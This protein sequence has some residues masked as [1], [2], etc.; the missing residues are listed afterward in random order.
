MT[1]ELIATTQLENIDPSNEN[2]FKS[3][4]DIYLGLG[5]SKQFST[6][7]ISTERKMDFK[8]KCRNFLIKACIGIRKRFALNEPVLVG[9]SKLNPASCLNIA[10]RDESI[11]KTLNLMPRLAPTSMDEQQA[12][13][14]QWRKLPKLKEQF[15]TTIRPDEFWHKVKQLE[16]FSTIGKYMLNILALP[17]SNAECERMF[18]QINDTKTKKRNRLITRTIRAGQR[19]PFR[20]NTSDAVEAATTKSPAKRRLV[21]Y[22][23]SDS[24]DV[25]MKEFIHRPVNYS[26]SH[27]EDD[28]MK[29][30]IHRPIIQKRL[31]IY[32]SSDS[33]II[34]EN[35]DLNN[36]VVPQ[37]SDFED[38]DNLPLAQLS[39][40]TPFQKFLPTPDYGITKDRPRKKALNYKG[41]RITKDLFNKQGN[42]LIKEKKK[43]SKQQVQ[44]RTKKVCKKNKN[45]GTKQRS[46]DERWYCNACQEER[47][48]DMRKCIKCLK[49]FH[50]DCVG[51]TKNDG[52]VF[53]CPNC[54]D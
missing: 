44:K 36:I 4:D 11:Q 29:K 20:A 2:N 52:E 17:N 50:D 18:S 6:N 16:E 47:M 35:V 34:D 14:D 8:R 41:Q 19:T 48:E 40:K 33:D 3:L 32:S 27:S 12:L 39:N 15:D 21:D 43:T 25:I 53:I 10:D 51:L 9:I 24:E 7:E 54:D 38:E 37:S 26:A 23:D 49:W 42:S 5:V 13:D 31:P 22:T 45:Q 28:I 46:P 1:T 30:F